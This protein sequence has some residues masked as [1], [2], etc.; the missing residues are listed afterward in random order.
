M[1]QLHFLNKTFMKRWNHL[2]ENVYTLEIKVKYDL[3]L[4][5]SSKTTT[6]ENFEAYSILG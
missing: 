2:G 1:I 6:S 4:G 5:K 3:C